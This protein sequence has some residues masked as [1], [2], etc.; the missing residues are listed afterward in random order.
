MQN[1]LVV[2]D[3]VNHTFAIWPKNSTSR[4]LN[5]G[6]KNMYLHKGLYENAYSSFTHNHQKLIDQILIKQWMDCQVVVHPYGG[7]QQWKGI[8]YTCQWDWISKA[9]C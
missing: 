7:I 6:N 4:Y 9:L 3:K 8:T 1:S 5:K 2:S